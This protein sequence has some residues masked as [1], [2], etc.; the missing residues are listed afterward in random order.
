MRKRRAGEQEQEEEEGEDDEKEEAGE[1][2]QGPQEEVQ[3]QQQE[4]RPQEWG[5][6]KTAPSSSPS[7]AVHSPGFHFHWSHRRPLLC[8]W[9]QPWGPR[10][11]RWILMMTT[12]MKMALR[13]ELGLRSWEGAGGGLPLQL[14]CLSLVGAGGRQ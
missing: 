8:R 14:S 10:T 13:L 7:S 6:R 4:E 11:G 3:W 5:G 2:E 12:T 1:G 9:R